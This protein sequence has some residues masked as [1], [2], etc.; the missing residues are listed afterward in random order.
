MAFTATDDARRRRRDEREFRV[1]Y[2]ASFLLV[3]PIVGLVHLI[4][5]PWRPNLAGSPDRLSVFGETRALI[6]STI[7]FAFMG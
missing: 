6:D 5:R 4:P 3:L 2:A 1:V 7:P